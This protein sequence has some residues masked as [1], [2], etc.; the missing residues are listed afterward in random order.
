MRKLSLGQRMKC[1]L[2]AALIHQP[3]I[4]FLDEPT[5]GLDVVV[6]KRIRAFLKEYNLNSKVTVILTSHNMDDVQELCE[7]IVVISRGKI[8][9]D[10]SLG[11]LLQKYAQRKYLKMVFNQKVAKVDLEK[12]GHLVSYADD[13]LS[14]TLSV[15]R[16]QHTRIA[17][18]ILGRLPVDD[19]D[20]AEA[21]LKEIIARVFEGRR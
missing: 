21:D 9:Y 20:I 11:K 4:L 15:D 14:A 1:E 16:V 5:I 2:M 7:R 3:K 8:I 13:G 18:E 10:G 19:L 12:Y 17:A 6:Q